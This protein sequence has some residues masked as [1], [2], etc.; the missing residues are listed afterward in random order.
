MRAAKSR[1][2]TVREAREVALTVIVASFREAFRLD[3]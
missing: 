2:A 1:H 3:G